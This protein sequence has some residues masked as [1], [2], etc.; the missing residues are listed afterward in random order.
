[1]PVWLSATCV[2]CVYLFVL[3]LPGQGRGV[4]RGGTPRPLAREAGEGSESEV[5]YTRRAMEALRIEIL[6][7]PDE[8]GLHAYCPA[9]KGLHVGG[10]T[11][12]EALQNACD[13]VM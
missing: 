3:L 11:V 5:R 9:L 1:M 12:E 10:N 2:I 8:G 4:K 6:I 7:E 13:A